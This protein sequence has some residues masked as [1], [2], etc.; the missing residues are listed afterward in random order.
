MWKDNRTFM[1]VEAKKPEKERGYAK[2]GDLVVISAGI[3]AAQRGGTNVMKLHRV[4][5]T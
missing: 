5:E 1:E 3:P 2:E 4:G